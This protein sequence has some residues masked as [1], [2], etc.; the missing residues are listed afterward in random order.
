MPN[1]APPGPWAKAGA[2]Y[3]TGAYS[4]AQLAAANGGQVPAAVDIQV[5]LGKDAFNFGSG[6]DVSV[7]QSPSFDT[8][9]G[10]QLANG[11]VMYG[12]TRTWG[13]VPI[14]PNGGGIALFVPGWL[15][16]HANLDAT[17]Q[18]VPAGQAMQAQGG[19][20]VQ[21]AADKVGSAAQKAIDDAEAVAKEHAMQI[22]TTTLI[23]GGVLVVL[24][25]GLIMI[26]R[27]PALP[28]QVAGSGVDEYRKRTAAGDA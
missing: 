23:V 17:L 14:D 27:N 28:A 2:S 25:V 10:T 7:W 18:V 24:I 26:D 11:G 13:A 16:F 15:D 9:V 1:T 20:N 12:Q 4:L 19:L 5:T 22:F 3:W 6:A 21:S 8:G